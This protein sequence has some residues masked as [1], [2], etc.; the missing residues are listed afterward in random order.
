M[1]V[2]PPAVWQLAQV[3]GATPVWANVTG[4]HAVVRWQASQKSVVRRCEAAA[5]TALP[6]ARWQLAQLPGVTPMCEYGPVGGTEAPPVARAV[7]P[8]VGPVDAP[9]PALAPAIFIVRPVV[10]RFWAAAAA[11]A[12]PPVGLWQSTQS[13]VALLPW[14]LPIV[15]VLMRLTFCH[16]VPLG[17][18][19]L[20][21]FGVEVPVL[22]LPLPRV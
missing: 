5:W 14:W 3:P 17:A 11:A 7:K 22:L 20:T 12:K 1:G 4:V 18:W 21:H 9:R 19:Q 16:F 8:E 15:A 10:G 2:A 6:P 13:A